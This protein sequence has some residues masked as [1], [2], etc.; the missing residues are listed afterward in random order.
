MDVPQAP[1]APQ[2]PEVP[3]VPEQRRP[4]SATESAVLRFGVLG[5]VRAW[6]GEDQLNTGSPS[7]A[8]CSPRSCSARAAPRPPPS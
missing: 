6:R 5:P 4:D 8:R 3:R 7:N 1:G 2:V